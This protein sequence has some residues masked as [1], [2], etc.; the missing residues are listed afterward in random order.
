ME[1]KSKRINLPVTGGD[2]SY[3]PGRL[4]CGSGSLD[5]FDYIDMK[6]AAEYIQ[7]SIRR[8]LVKKRFSSE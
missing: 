5:R 3:L 2:E 6:I 1:S 7:K 8:Y 4:I